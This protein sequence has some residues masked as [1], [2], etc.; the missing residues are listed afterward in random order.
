MKLTSIESQTI[1]E[2]IDTKLESETNAEKI[3]LLKALRV[4]VLN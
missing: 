1:L 2:L 3:K 4:K